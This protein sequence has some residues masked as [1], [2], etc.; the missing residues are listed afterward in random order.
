MKKIMARL[1]I[2]KIHAE[3]KI[4]YAAS[5]GERNKEHCE[6]AMAMMRDPA[7]MCY[8]FVCANCRNC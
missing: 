3:T 8:S 4:L 7:I 2:E 6:A 1:E 5:A